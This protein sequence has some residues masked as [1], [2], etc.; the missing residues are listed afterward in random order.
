VQGSPGKYQRLACAF[1]KGIPD[2]ILKGRDVMNLSENRQDFFGYFDP[3][4][5]KDSTL[6]IFRIA[7]DIRRRLGGQGHLLDDYLLH[8]LSSLDVT[9][10]FDAADSGFSEAGKLRELCYSILSGSD[11]LKERPLYEAVKQSFTKHPFCGE[12]RQAIVSLH[13]ILLADDFMSGAIQSFLRD[14]EQKR[15][16]ILNKPD[17]R[18]LR[19]KIAARI[20]EDLLERLDQAIRDRLIL[21]PIAAMFMQGLADDLLDCLTYQDEKTGRYAFQLLMDEL[22]K[23]L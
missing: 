11:E 21:A 18:G 5:L 1:I 19:K 9:H 15:E 16:E 7:L 6:K 8:V 2:H 4:K 17:S 20:G 23:E 3:Q 14:E 12:A 13:N 22:S 10:A